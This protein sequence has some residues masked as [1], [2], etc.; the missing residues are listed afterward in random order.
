VKGGDRK[1]ELLVDMF[2][3]LSL[4]LQQ[5]LR[6]SGEHAV[7]DQILTLHV[8]ERCHC[9]D[10][11]CASFYTQPRPKGPYGPGLRTVALEPITGHLIIDVVDGAVA[12]IEVL[13]RDEIRRKLLTKFPDKP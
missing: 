12:Q 2:P 4:E 9:G 7:A 8:L 1:S 10:D 3:E 13:Y 11:F 5:L 6:V